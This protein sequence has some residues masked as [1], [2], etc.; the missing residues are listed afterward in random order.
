MLGGAAL[1]GACL[2]AGCANQMSQRSEHEERTE[3]KPVEHHL[4][5]DAGDPLMEQPQR[6]VRVSEQATFEVTDFDVNRRYDRYT[7]Y[8][9][10]RELYE[11]PLGA[12]AVVAGVGANVLNVALFGRLPESV[13]HGWINYGF[14][15]INPFMNVQSNGRAEQNLAGI[16]E[17]QKDKRQELV[18][19]PWVEKPVEVTAGPEVYALN[20]DRKGY[21]RINLLDAPFA[22]QDMQRVTR[23]VLSVK[24]DDGTSRADA[25]LQLSPALRAKVAE[26]HKLIYDDLEDDDVAQWVHRVKRLSQLGLEDEANELQQSLLELTRNDPELQQEFIKAL[27]KEA[28]RTVDR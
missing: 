10:W 6:R 3:R 21:L 26:A 25:S 16:D 7:P 2:I 4:L 20:T 15:G 28:G 14:A 17:V 22:D 9:P 5:I 12:V 19:E 27:A 13:T 11:V 24:D 23:L 18:T 1:C 8:Q